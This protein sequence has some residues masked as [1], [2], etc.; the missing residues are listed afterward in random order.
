MASAPL[1]VGF[2]AVVPS[3]TLHPPNAEQGGSLMDEG[4]AQQI[5][6]RD[7][8]GRE[9][10]TSDPRYLEL[11]VALAGKPGSQMG[12]AVIEAIPP[13]YKSA[14]KI[15]SELL[16][17]SRHF[18]LLISLVKAASGELGYR[19]LAHSL[20][21]LHA[22]VD[23]CWSK[24]FPEADAE[25]E[26][27]PWWER[28]NVFRELTDGV[29]VNDAL[30]RSELVGVRHI[31]S[32]SKR[33]IDIAAGRLE[34]SAEEKERCNA[35]LI[36]GAFT[37]CDADTLS[38][39]DAAM[40]QAIELCDLLDASLSEHLGPALISFKALKDLSSQS[41]AEF[42]EY[43]GS[44]LQAPVEVVEPVAEIAQT[45]P[46]DAAEPAVK[47]VVT[48]QSSVFADHAAVVN[49]FTQ[50]ILFYQK[51]EPS[52]PVPFL[53]HR[54]RQMV[55]K[56]FFDILR[57]LAPQHKDDFRQLVSIL[58]DDPL[59][60]LLEHSF[61]AFVSGESFA[62]EDK[63]YDEQSEGAEA[64]E[65]D[66]PVK[67]DAAGT[68]A[69]ITSREQVLQTLLDIQRW[70]EQHEPS[71]PIPLIVMKVRSLVPKGFMDLLNEFEAVTSSDENVEAE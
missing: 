20:A 6:E 48:V 57:E 64:A 11:Q 3:S 36:R 53:L 54:A 43:A 69:E 14:L 45:D 60:F 70:F 55:F 39:I 35:N 9:D 13:D 10:I 16:E 37:E 4:L 66:A 51:F 68:A 26:E 17:Q 22:V 21:V 42:R 1:Q 47:T 62:A 71:S 32:F 34:V 59:S 12:D 65:N 46:A 27:D 29:A 19:G 49:A 40:T 5:A 33:D 24:S 58:K 50:L 56:N 2:L 61:T 18:D 7:S 52:S 25:D 63:T 8:P 31:G 67:S 30:Y 41:Q 28:L 44:R 23:A 38:A 15:C